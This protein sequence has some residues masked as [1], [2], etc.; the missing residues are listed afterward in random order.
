NQNANILYT[1]GNWS[2]RLFMSAMGGYS[3][4]DEYFSTKSVLSQNYSVSEPIVLNNRSMIFYSLNADYYFKPIKSNFKFT[5]GG[6]SSQF[7]N[8][9]NDSEI[10]DITSTSVNYGLEIRSGF[11]SEEH[12]SELQSRENLVC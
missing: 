11:R 2:D 9:V 6:N 12:T 7:Q 1:L 4:A 10:R 5:F 3:Y 8:Y